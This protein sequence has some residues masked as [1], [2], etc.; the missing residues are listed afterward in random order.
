MGGLEYS[1]TMTAGAAL[2]YVRMVVPWSLEAPV[3]FPESRRAPSLLR[4]HSPS[5]HKIKR[6]LV[7]CIFGLAISANAKD[8]PVRP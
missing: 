4:P 6:H 8:P 2:L 1:G 3:F 7:E 5:H